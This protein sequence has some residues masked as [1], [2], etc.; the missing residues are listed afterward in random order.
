MFVRDRCRTPTIHCWNN[1]RSSQPGHGFYPNLLNASSIKKWSFTLSTALWFQ[2]Q[3]M[4]FNIHFCSLHFPSYIEISC[5]DLLFI[6]ISWGTFNLDYN[7]NFILLHKHLTREFLVGIAIFCMCQDL[8]HKS[9]LR[10][11]CYFK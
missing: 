7:G 3:N 8:Q 5:G 9:F 10:R 2:A 6:T 1:K 11:L 4:L